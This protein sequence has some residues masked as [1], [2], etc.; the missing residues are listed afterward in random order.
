MESNYS[1]AAI[2]VTDEGRREV[3][4]LPDFHVASRHEFEIRIGGERSQVNARRIYV[5]VVANK[6]GGRI[7]NAEEQQSL[8]KTVLGWITVEHRRRE[9]AIFNV[10]GIKLRVIDRQGLIRRVIRANDR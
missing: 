5:Y 4:G 10:S 7:D 6:S 3:H 9:R 2:A 8:V 1:A